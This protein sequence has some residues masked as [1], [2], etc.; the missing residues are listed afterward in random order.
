M[1]EPTGRPTKSTPPNPH[2]LLHKPRIGSVPRVLRRPMRPDTR[3]RSSGR[4]EQ[5]GKT[6]GVQTGQYKTNHA[7]QKP[8]IGYRQGDEEAASETQQHRVAIRSGY[9]NHVDDFEWT[10]SLEVSHARE[11]HEC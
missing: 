2:D 5:I 8:K 11:A 3:R 4:S 6:R 10:S 1:V 7:Q 9:S